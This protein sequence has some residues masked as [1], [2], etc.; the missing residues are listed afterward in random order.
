VVTKSKPESSSPLSKNNIA[1]AYLRVSTERQKESGFSLINQQEAAEIYAKKNGLILTNNMILSEVKSASIVNKNSDDSDFE[2]SLRNRPVLLEIL[3]SAAQ[4]KF[5][6]II[7]F[8][9]DRLARD[10]GMFIALNLEFE[11]LNIK[12][13]Y[14][15]PGEI[16]E[17][18]DSKIYKFLDLILASVAELESNV[19]STRVKSGNQ[20]CIK[21]G[22][23]AGGKSP[24]GYVF[25]RETNYFTTKKNRHSKLK[26]SIYE[27]SIVQEIFELYI[28]G[29]SY[30]DIS[31]KM[32]VEHSYISWTKSKVETIIKN[33]TYTGKIAWNRRSGKRNPGKKLVPVYS[34]SNEDM[35]IIDTDLYNKVAQLRKRKSK[36]K[37]SRYYNTPFLLKNKLLCANC[38]ATL[39]PKNY[40]KDKT[41]VYRCPTLVQKSACNVSRKKSE[42]IV[43]QK[44]IEDEVIAQLKIIIDG[45]DTNELWGYYQ[46]EITKRKDQYVE[47]KKDLNNKILEVDKLQINIFKLLEKENTSVDIKERL[48]FQNEIL[49]KAK[50]QFLNKIISKDIWLEEITSLNKEKYD[51]AIKYFKNS[52]FTKDTYYSRV[53]IDTLIEH[54]VVSKIG[55][56]LLLKILIN[57]LQGFITP[58]DNKSI[59]N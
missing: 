53:L 5:Q 56:K 9:R 57:P 21:E 58:S 30:K 37:D 15:R 33:E 35:K 16:T 26:S 55:D 2:G 27:K 48:N 18:P 10:L 44:D 22:N 40:G 31:V 42:L 13:H 38:N 43:N 8:S 28:K 20:I 6:N 14:S 59:T 19:L 3:Q 54:I 1:V 49:N 50:Q 23:W 51:E 36:L 17:S 45:N 11:K 41:N 46:S 25:Q 34:P 52:I 4:N 29:Y 47:V 24:F 39:T 32:N 12:V 7:I